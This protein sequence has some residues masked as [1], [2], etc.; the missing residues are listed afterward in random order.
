[1][2]MRRRDEAPPVGS[3]PT[4]VSMAHTL[5]ST[6]V[7][8]IS[9]TLAHWRVILLGQAVSF[10]LAIAGATN[11]VL[12]TECGVSAPSTYNA[13]GYSV[14]A[15]FGCIKLRRDRKNDAR[16]ETSD[17]HESFRGY[18][19]NDDGD[20][21]NND[22]AADDDDLTLDDDPPARTSFFSAATAVRHGAKGRPRDN[23]SQYSGSKL[24]PQYPFL[25]GLFTIHAKWY[26]YFV[27]SFIEAQAY[28]FIFLAF[29]YTT[30]TFVY[31]SDAL[32]I[33]SS[34]LFTKLIMKRSYAWI[35][36]I[37]SAICIAGIVVNTLS[38]MKLEHGVEHIASSEHIKGDIYAI[39]GAV[40]LG[41]DDVLSEIIV[42]DYGGVTEMLFMKG[43]FGALI[44]FVQIGILERGNFYALFSVEGPCEMPW[45]M[46]LLATHVVTRA[47]DVA[48]EMQF[49]Y[50][51]EA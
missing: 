4:V 50:V 39:I 12:A 43:L 30:F 27:V 42:T 2:E 29:R 41:L 9:H 14:I 44:S 34:M 17:E 15:V 23:R 26:Y 45:R 32:A 5:T 1:M 46:G 3:T 22:D 31:V 11:E 20:G 16:N 8:G 7:E 40:L 24:R 28:Y 35:H 33:P 25:C 13:L 51:S 49:L 19:N 47:L 38:D 6:L 37:G 21:D 48:G 36:L 18:D 10:I